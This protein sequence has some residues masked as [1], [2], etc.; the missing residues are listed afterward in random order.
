MGQQVVGKSAGITTE[1]EREIVEFCNS[2]G[3][4]AIL[5]SVA[6]LI[7]SPEIAFA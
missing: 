4:C 6:Q 7:N 5:N 2:W 3:D 1:I